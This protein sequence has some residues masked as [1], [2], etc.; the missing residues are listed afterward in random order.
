LLMTSRSR[1]LIQVLTIQVWHLSSKPAKRRAGF[2]RN[3]S[4]A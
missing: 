3:M 4:T 2:A 1:L